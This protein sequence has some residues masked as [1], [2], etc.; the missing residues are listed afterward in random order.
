MGA[1]FFIAIAVGVFP[2]ELLLPSSKGL[3]CKLA[4]I[5]LFL[6]LI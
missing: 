5:A 3:Y 1:E 6:Y 2:I 4:E